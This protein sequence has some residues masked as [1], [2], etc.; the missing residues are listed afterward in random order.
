MDHWQTLAEDPT[1]VKRRAVFVHFTADIE[2]MLRKNVA[3]K[4]ANL[5]YQITAATAEVLERRGFS[6]R[7][8][9]RALIRAMASNASLQSL[10]DAGLIPADLESKLRSDWGSIMEEAQAAVMRG[11]LTLIELPPNRA[12]IW[13]VDSDAELQRSY[14]AIAEFL[15]GEAEPSTAWIEIAL[16]ILG[17]VQGRDQGPDSSAG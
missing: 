6:R 10:L 7:G 3:L 4:A 13:I 2:L 12:S 14:G 5:E 9:A 1:Q 16:P 15:C 8:M 11:L 17:R